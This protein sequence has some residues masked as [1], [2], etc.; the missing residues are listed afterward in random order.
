MIFILQYDSDPKT[1]GSST[2][3]KGF[4]VRHGADVTYAV[5]LWKEAASVRIMHGQRVDI[6]D[7]RFTWNTYLKEYSININDLSEITV[8]KQL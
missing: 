1:A 3:R 5:T 8:R 4:M 6:R 2:P 7:V